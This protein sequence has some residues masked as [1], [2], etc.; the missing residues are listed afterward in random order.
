MCYDL[1]FTS[2]IESIY[3]YLPELKDQGSLDFHFDPNYH[4]LAQSYLKWPV[5]TREDGQLRLK[6]FEWGVIA[7]YMNT[8]EKVKDSRPWMCNITSEKILNKKSFWNTI[9]QNRCLI[10]ATSFFEPHKEL[11]IKDSFWFRIWR[12]DR[13]V[14]F[15]PGLFYYPTHW[16]NKLTGEVVG[17]FGLITRPANDKMSMVHNGKK[18]EGRFR[19]PLLLPIDLEKEW[20][21]SDLSDEGI[22]KILSHEIPS[23]QLR[24]QH[25]KS[26]R[27]RGTP[28]DESVFEPAVDS[29]LSI[30]AA[31]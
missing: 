11:D 19:M 7:H 14:F 17:N 4:A 20:L 26:P 15:I 25:I 21:N 22:A 9:K 1:S 27:K 2:D 29:R 13:P 8:E 28:N 10:P 12:P 5:V 6:Q 3:D 30:P 24:Y 16:P 23:E 31:G 18:E